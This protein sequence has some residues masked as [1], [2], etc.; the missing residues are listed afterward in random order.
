MRYPIGT[1]DFRSLRRD[2]AAYVDK[3]REICAL[4]AA[5][6]Y[7]FLSRPRRF[8]KSL[9]VS[10]LKELFSDAPELFADTWA[11]EHWDFAAMERPVI[12]VKFASLGYDTL[13]VTG[14]LLLEIA[15]TAERFGVS[16]PG[17]GALREEFR[18]LIE[19]VAQTHES[20][21]CVVLVD[22]YDK[23]IVDYLATPERAIANR[24]ELRHFYG[25]LKDAEPHLEF[26]FITGVSAFSKVSLFS[27]LNNIRNLTLDPLA[28]TVVGITEEELLSNFRQELAA[29]GHDLGEVRHWYNGYTWGG[30]KVYNP[31]SIIHLLSSGHLDNYW[32]DSGTPRFVTDLMAR[33]GD[34][35]IEGTHA[36]K[37]ALLSFNLERLSRETVLWQGG[38]LT[39]AEPRATRGRYELRYPNEEVR[40]TFTETLLSSYGFADAEPTAEAHVLER[41]LRAR[42]LE[43]FAEQVDAILAGVPYQLWTDAAERFYHAIVLTAFRYIGTFE[44]RA[45]VASARGRADVVLE[46]DDLIYVIE[47]KLLRPAVAELADV[48]ARAAA[49]EALAGE[50]LAQI[51]ERGY[52]DPYRGGERELVVL[53]VVF[54]A[55]RRRVALVREA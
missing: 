46:W 52:A 42:D 7:F 36:T 15:R 55:E 12:W 23:A 45:E 28:H 6:R 5:G 18:A 40:Q 26:V 53:A 50:A 16:L 4:P 41:A 13:G 24:D 14:A 10:T 31:W 47:F 33:G 30:T 2:G 25:V 35:D 17:T 34:Y 37:P 29:T 49:A 38:Y 8:G 32:A 27:D 11:G 22:E 9:T 20:G 39:L 51:D 44:A 43:T 21:R 1:Q 54:D 48:V 3:T 19:G